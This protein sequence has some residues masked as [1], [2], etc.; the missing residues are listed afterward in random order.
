MTARRCVEALGGRAGPGRRPLRQPH[1]AANSPARGPA[2]S[3]RRAARWTCT[4]AASRP[5]TRVTT[6]LGPVPVLL[7]QTADDDS[8]RLYPAAA[9]FADFLGRWLLDAMAEFAAPEVP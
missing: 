7:W 8:Y 5:G 1:H 2:R 4:R 6:L 3:W 9:S